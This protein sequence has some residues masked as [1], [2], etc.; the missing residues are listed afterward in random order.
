MFR[1]SELFDLSGRTALVTG[2]NSGIGFALARALGLAGARTVLVARR[3]AELER[4]AG[5]LQAE[6]A[7]ASWT[8]MLMPTPPTGDMACAASP[9]QRRPG[10]HQR[11]RRSICTWLSISGRPS[12]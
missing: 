5:D 11:R 3:A 10:R 9:M 8:A 7:T 2:G 12:G 6:A 1:L 4:A